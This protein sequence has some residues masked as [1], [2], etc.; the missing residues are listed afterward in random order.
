MPELSRFF[1]ILIYMYF[2]DHPPPHF[3]AR[4]GKQEVQIAIGT[5]DVLAGSLPSAQLTL[6]KAWG[7]LRQRELMAA[8]EAASKGRHPGKILPLEGRKSPKK[9]KAKKDKK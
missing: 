7:I 8:W 2:N 6:V 4:Y 1:S 3:H 5:L 9:K